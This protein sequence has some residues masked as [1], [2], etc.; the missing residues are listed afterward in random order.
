MT[1]AQDEIA[2]E[3]AAANERTRHEGVRTESYAIGDLLLYH[4]NPQTV[5]RI[6]DRMGLCLDRVRFVAAWAPALVYSLEDDTVW[7]D[8][9]W[10]Q[11]DDARIDA[12]EKAERK[13]P[14][15]K[16]ASPVD[17][18][19]AAGRIEEGEKQGAA[20]R[21]TLDKRYLGDGVYIEDDLHYLILTLED[22]RSVINRIYLEPA[23]M[24]AMTQ[25]NRDVASEIRAAQAKAALSSLSE[26]DDEADVAAT[27]LICPVC[28]R[29]AKAQW[30]GLRHLAGDQCPSCR[31]G[32]LQDEAPRQASS[33]KQD[34]SSKSTEAK[35]TAVRMEGDRSC[36]LKNCRSTPTLSGSD[37][38][39]MVAVIDLYFNQYPEATVRTLSHAARVAPVYI[40]S[41]LAETDNLTLDYHD[42]VRRLRPPGGMA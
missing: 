38:D 18:M 13:S 14:N 39:C 11:P 1:S 29:T 6:A 40:R 5:A 20:R 7:Y 8:K 21:T 37:C 9:M 17:R 10:N 33:D 2:R 32:R 25:Y 36:V 15:S 28:K 34:E 22:G 31:R 19:E 16:D 3:I 35:S 4:G 26:A 30:T 42:V 24:D 27:G 41:Y 12:K 23:V